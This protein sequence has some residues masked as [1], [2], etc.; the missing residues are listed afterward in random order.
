MEARIADPETTSIARQQHGKHVSAVT[1]N[2]ATIE[3]LLEVVISMWFVL[4]L[5]KDNQREFLVS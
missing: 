2:H 1:N 3:E 5:Y 4:R